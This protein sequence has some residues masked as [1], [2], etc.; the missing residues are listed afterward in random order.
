MLL[1]ENRLWQDLPKRKYLHSKAITQ[2]SM[3]P[4]DS[5][6]WSGPM[7]M[8]DQFLFFNSKLDFGWISR[9]LINL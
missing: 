8:K 6:F 2:V 1:G 3:K 7:H 5:Q 4:G 9:V